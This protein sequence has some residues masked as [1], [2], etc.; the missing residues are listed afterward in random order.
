MDNKVSELIA[1][2]INAWVI[3]YYRVWSCF[4][5]CRANIEPIDDKQVRRSLD[6]ESNTMLRKVSKFRDML[7]PDD[8]TKTVS[9]IKSLHDDT[10]KIIMKSLYA[11]EVM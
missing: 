7:T 3:S 9:V 8:Y 5:I 6:A 11:E 10:F 2:N 1:T 4:L